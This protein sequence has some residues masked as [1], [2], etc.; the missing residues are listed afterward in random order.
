VKVAG[1]RLLCFRIPF[2][3]VFENAGGSASYREGIIFQLKTEAGVTGLGEASFLPQSSK[4]FTGLKEQATR[5]A[6]AAIGSEVEALVRSRSSCDAPSGDRAAWAGLEISAWDAI[7]RERSLPLAAVLSGEPWADVGVNALIS[8]RNAADAARDAA[9][10]R[11]AG[12]Q[13]VKLKVGMARSPSEEGARVAAVR[14]A[15]GPDIKLRLDVN[16]VWD[17]AQAIETISR[18][19]EFDL[20]YVEQ[21]VAAG[22]LDAIGKIREAASVPVALDEDVTDLETAIWILDRGAAD[23][24]ILKPIPMGGITA[25]LDIATRARAAGIKAI[26]TTSIDSGVGTAAALQLAASLGGDGVHGLATLDLLESSLTR[27]DLAVRLGRMPLPAGPGL[28][29]GLD[30]ASLSRY[31]IETCEY[32]SWG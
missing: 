13:T 7:A 30:K 15:L 6:E 12:Y 10:A 4:P 8:S 17:I 2:K 22:Q 19:A 21:P 11:A 18:F 32:G 26:V 25:A 28:G 24:L 14:G 27:P 9:Q 23:V 16:G 1:V 20:E 3:N 5:H 31:V 29:V